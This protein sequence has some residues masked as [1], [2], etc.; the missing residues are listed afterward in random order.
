MRGMSQRGKAGT[1]PPGADAAGNLSGTPQSQPNAR[2]HVCACVCLRQC[3]RL[4]V[5]SSPLSLAHLQTTSC[6]LCSFAWS[7]LSNVPLMMDDDGG[8]DV[9]MCVE[10]CSVWCMSVHAM[11]HGVDPL[12]SVRCSLRQA[13]RQCPGGR[14]R[15]RR[16]GGRRGCLL[17]LRSPVPDV[18]Q[19]AAACAHC[20]A[21]WVLCMR[22]RVCHC[23]WCV[24]ACDACVWCWCRDGTSRS[25]TAVRANLLLQATGYGGTT[26]SGQDSWKDTKPVPGAAPITVH[27]SGDTTDSMPWKFQPLQQSVKVPSIGSLHRSHCTTC[28]I[29]QLHPATSLSCSPLRL[30]GTLYLLAPPIH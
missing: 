25:T 24:C 27:F 7:G 15:R 22:V 23:R 14:V 6:Q 17:R 5:A 13:R 10:G 11:R 4:C 26:Q 21:W 9:G 3:C 8:G 12:V 28:T 19:G 29:E 20:M 2:I 1:P 18:L 30:A 16:C